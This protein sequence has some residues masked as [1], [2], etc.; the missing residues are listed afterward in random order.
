MNKLTLKQKIGVGFG[1]L[2]S[3]MVAVGFV[4]YWTMNNLE[5]IARDVKGVERK[6][7]LASRVESEIERQEA[8]AR[9]YVA[10]GQGGLLA[11]GEQ[12]KVNLKETLDE[13]N[14]AA[15]SGEEKGLLLRVQAGA[16]QLGQIE[17]IA[18]DYRRSNNLSSALDELFNEK[19][20][21]T[22]TE[23]RTALTEF[24]DFQERSRKEVLQKQSDIQNRSQILT[25]ACSVIGMVIGGF[26]AFSMGRSIASAIQR[27]LGLINEIAANNLAVADLEVTSEDELGQAIKALNGMKNNLGEVMRS[28]ASSSER[29]ASASEEI[30]A[31]ATQQAAGSDTQRDQT[32]QVATAMQEMSSTILEISGNSSKAADAA[33]KASD[34]ARQGGKIVEETLGKMRGIALSVE[35]TAKKVNGLGVRSN[36]IGQIIGVIDDIAD[37]TNLLA[38][39]AAIEAARAGEQGRG[40]AVVA[41]EVRKLAERTSKAT[42]EI[43]AMIQSIQAETKSAVEAMEAG[44]KQVEAGVETTQQAG[45]SLHEIIESAEQVGEMVTHIATAATEQSAATE[46]VNSNLEQIAKITGETA[47]GAQQSAKACH[48]LSSLAL[49][50]QNLVS[51]FKLSSNG[52]HRSARATAHAMPRRSVSPSRK[53]ESASSAFTSKHDVE[54]D[55]TEEEVVVR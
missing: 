16:N 9:G 18:G 55:S 43:A 50:L 20:D 44:T 33:R 27:M 41:D 46:E 51:Q 28:I 10:T 26:V 7:I 23:L 22:R 19:A 49:D 25:S 39:N 31:S 32:G 42:K 54:S 38:L 47:E 48:D 35:D 13:L 14:Q 8:A 3:V 12:T 37:Q 15:A 45:T 30:S 53:H 5:R 34:T 1:A 11:F 6:N 24:A 52:H 29:L 4:S 36:Q 21:R 17:G 2:L 40:F